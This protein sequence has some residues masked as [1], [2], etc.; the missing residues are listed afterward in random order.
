MQRP[1]YIATAQTA[2]NIVVKTALKESERMERASV[3]GGGE[4]EAM[5]LVSGGDLE[6]SKD[7]ACR[8]AE[9]IR[10]TWILFDGVQGS[11]G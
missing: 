10:G 1:S 7:E 11:Q 3:G 2:V 9:A 4:G 6:S 8:E 5:D